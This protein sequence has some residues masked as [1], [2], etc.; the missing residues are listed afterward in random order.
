MVK[1]LRSLTSP[2]GGRHAGDII[3]QE[4]AVGGGHA[5]DITCGVARMAASHGASL[6]LR[7]ASAGVHRLHQW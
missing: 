5:G 4:S 1:A 6:L 3:L 7:A 2:V